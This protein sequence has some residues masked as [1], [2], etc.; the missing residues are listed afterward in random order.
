MGISGMKWCSWPFNSC[1]MFFKIKAKSMLKV[2]FKN[3]DQYQSS[4]F[5]KNWNFWKIPL[6]TCKI[7]KIVIFFIFR[8]ISAAVL[9]TDWA[10]NPC[11]LSK[12]PRKFKIFFVWFHVGPT[13][14]CI[15]IS[16]AR[17]YYQ[18]RTVIEPL[19]ASCRE[20]S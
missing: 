20:Q 5:S 3:I 6:K 18:Y 2:S 9:N 19:E 14:Q 17:I 7:S 12:K 16:E 4:K 11:N 13:V 8:S 15:Q 10:H 1:W